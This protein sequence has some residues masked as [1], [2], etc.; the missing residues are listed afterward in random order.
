VQKVDAIIVCPADSKGIGPAIERANEAMIPVFTADIAAQ[1]GNVV[2]HVASDNAINDDSALGAL[3]A[4]EARGRNDLVIVGY[5][6]TPE[7][8]NAIQ[9]GSA[10]KAY[11]AQQPPDMGAKTIEVIQTYLNNGQVPPRVSVPVGIV[12]A[13]TLK[14]PGVTS[15]K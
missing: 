4:A 11:V 10:V 14:A 15:V 1:S 2:S 12:D 7:A 3:S 8:V 9:R 6:A 5:D 13:A